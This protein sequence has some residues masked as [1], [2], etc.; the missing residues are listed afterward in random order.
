MLSKQLKNLSSADR[1]NRRFSEAFKRSKV[2]EIEAKRL[3]VSEV[4]YLYEV[5]RT[6][7]HRWLKKY[8][9]KTEKGVKIVIEM[10]SE[11]QRTK[12]LQ[13][14]VAELE[15]AVGLKQL[16]ID[17][18]NQML[19]VESQELGYDLKKKHGLAQSS[20]FAVKKGNI[21]I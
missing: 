6:S 9:Q 13:E 18:L 7:V 2:K 16:E 12:L 20:I 1:R 14:R 8:G 4:C 5:S 10:Q 3:K 19:I 11:A 21:I 15:R 17:Y